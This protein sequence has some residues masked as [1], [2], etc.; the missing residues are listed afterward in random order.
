MAPKII[1]LTSLIRQLEQMPHPKKELMM[2]T[3]P[4]AISDPGLFLHVNKIVEVA[5]DL[6]VNKD[7]DIDHQALRV[8]EQQCVKGRVSHCD[9]R[10]TPTCTLYTAKGAIALV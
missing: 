7:G 8:L 5:N 6:L 9:I 1:V 2:L 10:D 3:D 4:G